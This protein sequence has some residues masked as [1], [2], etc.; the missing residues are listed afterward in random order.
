MYYK[1]WIVEKKTTDDNGNVSHRVTSSYST[2]DIEYELGVGSGRALEGSEIITDATGFCVAVKKIKARL[3]NL[4][5]S[6]A[7]AIEERT[8][9]RN[10]LTAPGEPGYIIPTVQI[11]RELLQD[12]EALDLELTVN[13]TNHSIQLSERNRWSECT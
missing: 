1:S 5:N 10:D 7:R 4:L 9:S 8:T 3:E 13:P 6:E 12:R 2:T 11:S